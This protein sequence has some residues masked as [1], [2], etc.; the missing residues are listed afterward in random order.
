MEKLKP[1]GIW[2]RVSTE[3]QAKGE[4]PEHHEKRAQY[5]AESK[6]WKVKEVYHLE[7]VS[8]KSVMNHPE[9][10]RMLQGIRSDHITDLTFSGY[11]C[12]DTGTARPRRCEMSLFSLFLP[13]Q[14][15]CGKS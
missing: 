11:L 12:P 6:G 2:L 7:A 9:T 13:G 8:G 14:R 10:Q 5:Y 3:D 15:W 4:S 1:V